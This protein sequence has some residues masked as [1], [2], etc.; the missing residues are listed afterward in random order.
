MG[1][2]RKLSC[3]DEEE[4]LLVSESSVGSRPDPMKGKVE[5]RARPRTWSVITEKDKR[6][7]QKIGEV[8]AILDG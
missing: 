5:K 7:A 2:H 6:V 3:G 8:V 4:V 1:Q